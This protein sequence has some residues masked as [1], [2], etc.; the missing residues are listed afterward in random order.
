MNSALCAAMDRR[1]RQLRETAD[2]RLDRLIAMERNSR[3]SSPVPEVRRLMVE[4]GRAAASSPGPRRDG[5]G[6]GE[7]AGSTGLLPVG[8]GTQVPDGLLAPLFQ[9]LGQEEAPRVFHRRLDEDDETSPAVVAELSSAVGAGQLSA[10]DLRGEAGQGRGLEYRDGPALLEA[11][12]GLFGHDRNGAGALMV[13][14]GVNAFWSSEVR[15]AAAFEGVPDVA[16]LQALPPLAGPP[17][18]FGPGQALGEGCGGSGHLHPGCAA[19]GTGLEQASLRGA[20]GGVGLE[21]A[22][23]R[24]A[25]GSIGPEQASLR[26]AANG[27]GLE[28]ASS[29]GMVAGAGPAQAS[30]SWVATGGIGP[31]QALGAEG[32]QAGPVQ[33]NG[34]LLDGGPGSLQAGLSGA[35]SQPSPE[36]SVEALRLRIVKAAEESF[37]REA[38][39]LKGEEPEGEVRSYH[40]ASSGPGA[41][42]R[43]VPPMPSLQGAPTSSLVAVQ[44]GGAATYVWASWTSSRR[45]DRWTWRWHDV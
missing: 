42:G 27:I 12:D 29:R 31:G 40:T 3:I 4:E 5:R 1:P 9:D 23:S 44:P 39:K 8:S 35:L 43:M 13:Q 18:S 30:S 26:C 28:Q 34:A 37:I 21:Q 41:N 33:A 14:P 15:R 25:A 22:S 24:C 16:R 19:G 36:K 32:R 17:V 10:Q 45:S 20:A 2:E 11:A 38:K 6:E 7:A